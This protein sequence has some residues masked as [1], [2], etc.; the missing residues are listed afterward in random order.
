MF[1][2]YI[3]FRDAWNAANNPDGPAEDKV[4]APPKDDFLTWM[5]SDG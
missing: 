5:N 1:W 4:E 3:A 2:E